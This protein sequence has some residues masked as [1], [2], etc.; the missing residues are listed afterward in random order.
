MVLCVS[1]L[2]FVVSVV[3]A[4]VIL[5]MSLSVEKIPILLYVFILSLPISSVLY[6]V[7]QLIKNK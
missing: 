6:G 2:R 1:V 3:V 4:S 7:I 5:F